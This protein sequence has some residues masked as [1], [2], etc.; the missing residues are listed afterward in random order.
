M[1]T[2]KVMVGMNCPPDKRFEPGDVVSD[3]DIP[4]KSIKWLTEDG[5]I[6]LQETTSKKATPAAESDGE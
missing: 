5:V 3:K 6:V 4:A 2:Y 1:A